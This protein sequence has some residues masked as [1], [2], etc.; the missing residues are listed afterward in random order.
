MKSAACS[1]SL[2]ERGWGRNRMLNQ[3]PWPA[4]Q[5]LALWSFVRMIAG[6]RNAANRGGG[7]IRATYLHHPSHA[8]RSI[9]FDLHVRQREGTGLLSAV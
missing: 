5:P 1:T 6:D 7:S 4:G 2:S 3:L 9:P 8:I